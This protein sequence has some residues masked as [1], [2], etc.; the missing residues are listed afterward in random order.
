MYETS[1]IFAASAAPYWV[2]TKNGFVVT[3]L[4]NANFHLGAG[5]YGGGERVRVGDPKAA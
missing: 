4:M 3:W 2:G 1:S 5:P